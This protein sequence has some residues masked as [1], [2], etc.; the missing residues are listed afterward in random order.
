MWSCEHHA[1][2]WDKRLILA[3]ALFC[4]NL[5]SECCLSN[6]CAI[7]A[8]FCALRFYLLVIFTSTT[9]VRKYLGQQTVCCLQLLL[10][11]LVSVKTRR[12]I[13]DHLFLETKQEQ[14]LLIWKK[15]TF[16]CTFIIQYSSCYTRRG[17][18]HS[19]ACTVWGELRCDM[20]IYNPCF[21]TRGTLQLSQLPPVLPWQ[22]PQHQDALSSRHKTA[23]QMPHM[24][25][26]VRRRRRRRHFSS[27]WT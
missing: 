17:W 18:S 15:I 5:L 20:L 22:A 26:C 9:R 21:C 10:Q 3:G 4:Y 24:A 16:Y 1:A 2:Y 14:H 7:T 27:H 19:G 13:Y 8:L 6:T 11:V 23:S 12:G 25:W